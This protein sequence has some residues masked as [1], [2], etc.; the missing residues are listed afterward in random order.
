MKNKV[1][2]VTTIKN[3]YKMKSFMNCL[4]IIIVQKQRV[5]RSFKNKNKN[6]NKIY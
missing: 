1:D 6:K 3:K 4:T 5:E 2:V